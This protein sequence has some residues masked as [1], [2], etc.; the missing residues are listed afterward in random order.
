MNEAKLC[1]PNSIRAIYGGIN[2]VNGQNVVHGSLTIEE[3]RHEIQFF[4]PN[5]K[6]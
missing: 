6:T 4:F 2:G 1:F 5:C 3:A